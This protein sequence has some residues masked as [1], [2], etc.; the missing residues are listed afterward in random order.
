MSII[1][2]VVIHP[3]ALCKN[4]LYSFFSYTFTKMHQFG[5]IIR[6]G[7]CKFLHATEA[8]KIG[9]LCPLL[10]NRVVRN[11][12]QMFEDQQITYQLDGLVGTTIV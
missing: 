9:I 1:A 10:Y 2:F 7:R 6:K 4:K 3:N 8:L 12:T 11:V 5:G